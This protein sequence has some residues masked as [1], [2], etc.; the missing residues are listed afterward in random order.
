MSYLSQLC[1]LIWLQFVSAAT[2]IA[3]LAALARGLAGRKD[4]GNFFVDVQPRSLCFCP[5]P[6]CLPR[7]WFSAACR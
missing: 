2:G 7:L 6:S 4:L 5:L 3:V 1:A